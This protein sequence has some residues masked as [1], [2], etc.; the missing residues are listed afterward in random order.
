MPDFPKDVEIIWCKYLAIKKGC[1]RIGYQE[2]SAYTHITGDN[3][4][5]WE[6]D[7]LIDL[8]I[9]RRSDG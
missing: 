6:V 8:D 3:L 2:L 1:E 7:L 4:T 5:P 9:L